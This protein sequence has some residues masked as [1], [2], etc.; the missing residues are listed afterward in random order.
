M[1]LP[2]VVQAYA[3]RDYSV[4]VQYDDGKV[5]RFPVRPL[6]EQGGVFAALGDFDFFSRHITVLNGTVAWSW[7][8]DPQ[9]CLDLDP[10]VV[11][12]Q[13]QKIADDSLDRFADVPAPSPAAG[14]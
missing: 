13:G 5:V 7:D 6:V 2:R 9:N 1:L 12:T 14:P 4:V 10:L 3:E 8:F 11:Y